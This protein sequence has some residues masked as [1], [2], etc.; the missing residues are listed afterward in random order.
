LAL[1]KVTNAAPMT[2]EATSENVLGKQI[3]DALGGPENIVDVDNCISRLRLIVEDTS[4]VDKKKL[5]ST[6]SMGI[7]EIDKN[8][9][10]VVYGPKVESAAQSLKN[11][12]KQYNNR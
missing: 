2:E 11:E 7:N 1:E 3:L 12:L 9:I 5:E 6:G 4:I 8:N 10:Q